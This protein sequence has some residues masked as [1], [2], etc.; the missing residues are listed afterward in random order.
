MFLVGVLTAQIKFAQRDE[1][2]GSTPPASQA[3]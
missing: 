3:E 2:E 1:R